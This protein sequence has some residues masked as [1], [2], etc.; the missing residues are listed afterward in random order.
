MRLWSLVSS[1][2]RSV[3]PSSRYE[4]D[5]P[6]DA[7]GVPDGGMGAGGAGGAGGVEATPP[8]GRPK[9]SVAMAISVPLPSVPSVERR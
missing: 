8:P 9:V 6:E 3:K 5:A 4:G 2:E 1:H 7:D